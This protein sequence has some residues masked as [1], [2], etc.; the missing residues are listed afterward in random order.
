MGYTP[1]YVVYHELVMTHKE[2][3]LCVSVVVGLW[4]V[5][6]GPMFYSIKETGTNRQVIILNFY[7]LLIDRM[8]CRLLIGIIILNHTKST[9]IIVTS[10]TVCCSF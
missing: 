9:C 4:L 6:L 2:Y 8:Y 5:D 3:M 1:D 10:Y 7:V